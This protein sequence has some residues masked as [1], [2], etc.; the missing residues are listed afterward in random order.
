MFGCFLD[1]VKL[2]PPFLEWMDAVTIH[3]VFQPSKKKKN[4]PSSP[5]QVLL[6]YIWLKLI[7]FISWCV[8]YGFVLGME[9][10]VDFFRKSFST[11]LEVCLLDRFIG[12]TDTSFSF[13]LLEA[14][15]K[16]ITPLCKISWLWFLLQI[17]PPI[18]FNCP[19]S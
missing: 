19:W 15:G 18:N 11:R 7:M 4:Y 3:W 16:I 6:K 2:C 5:C 9:S 17:L 10:R 1:S 14:A 8:S 12:E 13:S